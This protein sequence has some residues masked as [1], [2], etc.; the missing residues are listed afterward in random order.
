MSSTE[1]TFFRIA[2][3]RLRTTT[4]GLP[5]YNTML[6]SK[7]IESLNEE[8]AEDDMP[9]IELYLRCTDDVDFHNSEWFVRKYLEN[10]QRLEGRLWTL[11]YA[12]APD[13]RARAHRSSRIEHA[14]DEWW[15]DLHT[16]VRAHLDACRSLLGG[17][18]SRR[19]GFEAVASRIAAMAPAIF[20]EALWELLLHYVEDNDAVLIHTLVDRLMPRLLETQAE[21]CHAELQRAL[22]LLP[23]YAHSNLMRE[24][25]RRALIR[26][27]FVP[28][29]PRRELGAD[30]RTRMRR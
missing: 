11:A 29:P 28:M 12:T 16:K 22:A 2:I 19:D 30:T 24:G 23:E 21:V 13:E 27:G 5:T 3:D 14:R 10:V 9:F 25:V 4:H 18:L 17:W 6:H 20:W 1:L 15:R 26:C 7:G 8:E